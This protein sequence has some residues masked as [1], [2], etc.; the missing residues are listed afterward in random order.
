LPQA[1][2]LA[3]M[4]AYWKKFYNTPLGAGKPEQ[5]VAKWRKAFPQ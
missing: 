4:A 1:G 5:F 3:A 2:D